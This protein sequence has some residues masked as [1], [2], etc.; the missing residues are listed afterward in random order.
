MVLFPY[1][2]IIKSLS[3]ICETLFNKINGLLFMLVLLL[4]SEYNPD[5]F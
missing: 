5:I 2:S 1:V 4:V 3:D